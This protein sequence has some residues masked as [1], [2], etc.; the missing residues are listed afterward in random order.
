MT[1]TNNKLKVQMKL[2]QVWKATNSLINS[3]LSI[4]Y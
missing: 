3:L 4:I 2:I 1:P